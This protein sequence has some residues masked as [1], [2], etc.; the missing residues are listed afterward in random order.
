MCISFNFSIGVDVNEREFTV[1]QF[2]CPGIK[3]RTTLL[4]FKISKSLCDYRM[5]FHLTLRRRVHSLRGRA[6]VLS[7]KS[8]F[9]VAV[10]PSLFPPSLLTLVSIYKRLVSIHIEFLSV[11]MLAAGYLP[12]LLEARISLGITTHFHRHIPQDHLLVMSFTKYTA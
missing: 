12:A 1:H 9:C 3:V 11:M 6:V 2:T 8:C 4:L 5:K 10:C 7:F